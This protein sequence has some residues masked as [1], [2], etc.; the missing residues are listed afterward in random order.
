[1]T[2]P[3]AHAITLDPYRSASFCERL[4]LDL[5]TAA[6]WPLQHDQRMTVLINIM[7]AEIEAIAENKDQVDAIVD[8]LRLQLKLNMRG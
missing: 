3:P 8:T 7:A 2:R 4:G 5:V 6:L 1:M